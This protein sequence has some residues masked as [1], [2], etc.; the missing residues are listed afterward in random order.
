[1]SL[2]QIIAWVDLAHH[3]HGYI[4]LF[5]V[6]FVLGVMFL[7]ITLFPIVGGV[8]LDYPWALI[9]NL[10]SATVGGAFSFLLTRNFGR[11]KVQ[12]F[13]K[14]KWKVFDHLTA[15]QGFK[16]VLLL[17]LLGVPPFIVTNYVLGLSAVKLK[18]F[19]LGTIAGILPWMAVVTY[20]ARSL[21]EAALVGGEHG[22]RAALVDLVA[23]FSVISGIILVITLVG[24][25][26]RPKKPNYS[27]L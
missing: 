11:E 22:F 3:H 19:I 10:F 13:L 15:Q 18:D 23:P 27:N 14:G 12:S 9:L 5:Y 24:F 16:S 1:M 8:L 25:L 26:R 6:L 17:R 20:A 21:W 7:P 2:P 4:A